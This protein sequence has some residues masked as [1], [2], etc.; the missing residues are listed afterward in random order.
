MSSP[1]H[2]SP[3]APSIPLRFLGGTADS[4]LPA[5]WA[6]CAPTAAQVLDPDPAPPAP[7]CAWRSSS[8][9]RVTSSADKS[10]ASTHSTTADGLLRTMNWYPRPHRRVP[11]ICKAGSA[12]HTPTD[13][14]G[15]AG[16]PRT[17]FLALGV[18]LAARRPLEPL[19]P[20]WSE[21]SPGEH[22]AT[23]AAGS[24]A[25]APRAAWRLRL[26]QCT[27]RLIGR[28]HAS[29]RQN[30]VVQASAVVFG[31][32]SVGVRR[33]VKGHSRGWRSHGRR[34]GWRYGRPLPAPL[35]SYVHSPRRVGRS[36]LLHLPSRSCYDY[37]RRVTCHC[38]SHRS[39]CR[40]F[41]FRPRLFLRAVIPPRRLSGGGALALR[42]SGRR[43]G[44]AAEISRVRLVSF[45][46]CSGLRKGLGLSWRVGE[47][48]A[49]SVLAARILREHADELRTLWG[50]LVD[51]A[52]VD[53]EF[54]RAHSL[55]PTH[56]TR[57]ATVGHL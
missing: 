12:G 37:R 39:G 5:G 20:R 45:A 49:Q 3:R 33:C 21:P 4:A 53:P 13:P 40:L 35:G 22:A 42:G 9:Y 2:S 14:P 30:T 19:A 6:T 15:D 23:G 52:F 18:E 44:A 8:L 43:S 50:A 55:A 7:A 17:P 27:G 1:L 36:F 47:W 16:E 32:V 34:L 41:R 26:A 38:V 54:E 31:W 46:P 24:E 51:H 57:R 11:T 28:Y 56:A 48:T 25:A 10:A 29:R